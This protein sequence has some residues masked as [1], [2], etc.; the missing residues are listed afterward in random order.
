MK[1][2][3][4]SLVL[5]GVMALSM[6]GTASTVMAAGGSADGEHTLSVYAWDA[7]FNIP[8]LKAA[9]EDYKANVDP[10][11]VLNI[12]EQ[13]G[14]SD[15]ENAVTLAA[16]SGDY[17]QLPDIVLF[18]DHWIQKFVAD[19]PD[20]WVALEGIDIDWSD[21]GEEKLSYSTIDGAHYGVPVDNGTAIFAYRVDILEE[22]GYTIDD[23][24][25]C[26]WDQFIEIGKK[27]YETTG[28]YLL[29]MDGSG[30][31]LPYM[32]LQAEGASQFKDGEPYITE[33]ETMVTI[34]EKIVEMIQNNVLYLGNDWSDYTDQ[35]IIG[36]MV[37]GVMNG[38]WIIPT[39]EQVAENSGKGI[40]QIADDVVSS[41][42]G[43]A[44]T[45]VDGVARLT[46]DITRELVAKLGKKNLAK[47]IYVAYDDAEDGSKK[48]KV[49][50]SIEIKFGYN[51]LAV[52]ESVQEKVKS[53]LLTM[54]GLECSVVNVKVSGIDFED[55]K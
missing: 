7:N 42:V 50:V 14:S 3:V 1:K 38:N 23:L 45:E 28:K 29:S 17:S 46:G 32:L 10:D 35:T 5:T 48:V 8:A 47:G 43:L 49:N 9:E 12:V 30:N 20:A 19:Y 34:I 55:Q 6:I 44:V 27:V 25:G 33:N 21:F 11:F 39:I 2:K 31:D 22:C 52:S 26:S 16:S 4:M 54:T 18:Q 40:V 37:A 13:S 53:T 51:I 15:V 24:T 36:D 41:I